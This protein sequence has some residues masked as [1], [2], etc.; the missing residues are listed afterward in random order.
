M[1]RDRRRKFHL[2]HRLDA[3]I[4]LGGLELG[5]YEWDPS[6]AGD[7]LEAHWEP[8]SLGNEHRRDWERE[9]QLQDLAARLWGQRTQIRDLGLPQHLQSFGRETLYVAGEHESR[10]GYLGVSN[11]PVVSGSRLDLLELERRAQA[12]EQLT[13]G[14]FD[15]RHPGPFAGIISK[16]LPPNAPACCLRRAPR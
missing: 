9:E 1:Q 8:L 2:Q 11:R 12:I 7:F 10:A 5:A 16:P 13:D 15:S 14:Y 6:S 3:S 4:E